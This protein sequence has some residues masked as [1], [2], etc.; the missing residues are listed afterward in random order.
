MRQL[1]KVGIPINNNEFFRK[2]AGSS[3]SKAKEL[4]KGITKDAISVSSPNAQ[5]TIVANM[6]NNTYI[7]FRTVSDTSGVV[8]TIDMNASSV[9]S[10]IVKLKFYP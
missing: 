2:I 5:G 8:A 9:F 1:S 4:F 6:G 10:Q 7:T 3:I